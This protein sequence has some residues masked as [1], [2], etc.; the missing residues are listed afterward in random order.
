MTM[1]R[2]I[3]RYS[4]QDR[5]Q[6]HLK[7]DEIGL[8]HP[9]VLVVRIIRGCCTKDPIGP[10]CTVTMVTM[11]ETTWRVHGDVVEVHTEA[12]ALCVG[13]GEQP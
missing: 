7:F 6:R 4:V 12:V 10:H 13:I 3:A 1:D 11:G 5:R 9:Q 2:S 8:V